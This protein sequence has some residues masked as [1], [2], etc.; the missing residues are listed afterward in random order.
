MCV[1]GVCSCAYVKND[2]ADQKLLYCKFREILSLKR[3]KKKQVR[4]WGEEKICG[5]PIVV[6]LSQYFSEEKTKLICVDL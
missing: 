6:Y 4:G 2:Y 3:K 1:C 5:N